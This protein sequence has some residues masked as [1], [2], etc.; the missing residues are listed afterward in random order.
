M[1][2]ED[3]PGVSAEWLCRA[4]ANLGILVS[5]TVSSV[6]GTGFGDEAT[7]FSPMPVVIVNVA[8]SVG[9]ILAPVD[10]DSYIPRSDFDVV[11]VVAICCMWV[12][13]LAYSHG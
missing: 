9:V 7:A 13:T 5:Y 10:T 11:E 2:P 1:V 8:V 6:S 3:E 4:V 12:A